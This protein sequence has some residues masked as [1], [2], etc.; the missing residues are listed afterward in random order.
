MKY[1]PTCTRTAYTEDM[2]YAPYAPELQ[3]HNK[4]QNCMEWKHGM[5][6][7]SSWT[8]C[9]DGMASCPQAQKLQKRML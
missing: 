2:A 1:A 5:R 6:V 7:A 4:L 3:M 8:A 9:N